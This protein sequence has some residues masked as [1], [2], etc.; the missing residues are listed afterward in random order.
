MPTHPDKSIPEPWL[1][2][3]RELD[4]A[5]KEQVR[6]DCIGGFVVTMVYG[7]SRATADLDVLEIVPTAAGR[8]LLELGKQGSPLHR[9]YKIY[10][11]RV[12]VAKVP[13]DYENRL[14]EIFAR[15]FKHLRLLALDPYDLALSKLERNLQRDR[16]DVLHLA[17]T[18]PFDLDVLKERY[19][20]ELRW[21]MGNPDREDLTLRLWIE[22][23]EEQRSR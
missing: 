8:S 5:M 13:E 2:F 19:Q 22:A 3:L 16:D 14:T 11:D 15:V 18:V 7:F 21:Q 9:K 12:G 4:C 1:S 6:L 23:I 17:R 20:K 10:L